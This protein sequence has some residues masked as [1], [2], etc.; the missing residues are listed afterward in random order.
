MSI[1]STTDQTN[2]SSWNVSAVEPVF[3]YLSMIVP[4]SFQS[5][6]LKSDSVSEPSSEAIGADKVWALSRC[7]LA[8][9]DGLF[10]TSGDTRLVVHGRKRWH[11]MVFDFSTH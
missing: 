4:R 2:L 9:C 10:I 8:N 5:E 11:E 1:K 7:S 3:P 6:D